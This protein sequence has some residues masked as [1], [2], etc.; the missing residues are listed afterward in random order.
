MVV[1]YAGYYINI[2][3]SNLFP[4][5]VL[6]FLGTVVEVMFHVPPRKANDLIETIQGILSQEQAK[7][8]H[9]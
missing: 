5:R 2:P 4:V 6:Q 8:P 9:N 7:V 1:F 3:K